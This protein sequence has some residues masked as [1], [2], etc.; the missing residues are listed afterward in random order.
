MDLGI[1]GRVALVTASTKGIG[2]KTAE[3][4]ALEGATVCICSR[5]SQHLK[6]AQ[7][8]IYQST[9]Q[10]PA[11]YAADMTKAEDIQKQ[12]GRAHV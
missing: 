7:E 10:R 8:Q 6:E 3:L 9:G 1:K 12:I 5:D 4:L 11:A 2:Y